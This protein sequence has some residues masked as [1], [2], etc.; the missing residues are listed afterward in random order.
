[1]TLQWLGLNI[2]QG[3][4]VGFTEYCKSNYKS[5]NKQKHVHNSL[6][7]LKTSFKFKVD[8]GNHYSQKLLNVELP[9]NVQHERNFFL[10]IFRII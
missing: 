3:F 4:Q 10:E 9:W 2:N 5:K 7:V 8:E 1:M 6:V